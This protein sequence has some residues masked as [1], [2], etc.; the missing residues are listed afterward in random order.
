MKS[1]R[2]LILA[3]S[4][5]LFTLVLARV[6]QTLSANEQPASEL[7]LPAVMLDYGCTPS[8]LFNDGFD[9][10]TSGW[11]VVDNATVLTRYV[12]SSYSIRL[13]VPTAVAIFAPT[14]Q[15][16]DFVVSVDANAHT[17]TSDE[18]F[19]AVMFGILL[20]DDNRLEK[21]NIFAVYPDSNPTF[22]NYYFAEVQNGLITDEFQ[23]NAPDL[24]NA[25]SAVNQLT[26]EVVDGMAELSV[27]GT[28]VRSKPIV[29]GNQPANLGLMS[30]RWGGAANPVSDSRFDNFSVGTPCQSGGTTPT[31]NSLMPIQQI[32]PVAVDIF[33]TK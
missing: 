32:A 8:P 16:T 21:Y 3:A 11:A 28:P 30:F 33:E 9:D 31:S 29:S 26:V 23:V 5:L 1:V 12:N 19:Q 17:G 2:F 18:G 27:N 10:N 20:D 13:R 24:I 22:R 14:Q 4:M 25:G 7:L 6:P 15:V